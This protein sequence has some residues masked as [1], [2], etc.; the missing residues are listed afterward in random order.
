MSCPADQTSVE[1]RGPH[2]DRAHAPL[3]E[4][5][6]CGHHLVHRPGAQRVALGEVVQCERPDLVVDA[7]LHRAAHRETVGSADR[8]APD[9]RERRLR[10]L[11]RLPQTAMS[12]HAPRPAWER[13]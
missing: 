6:E 11:M 13:S 1:L 8:T 7:D 9:R 12:H 4:V 2:H 5:A 3:L 10:F